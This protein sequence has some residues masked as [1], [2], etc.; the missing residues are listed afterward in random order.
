MDRPI[1]YPGQTPAVEDLLGGFRGSYIG[2]GTLLNAVMDAGTVVADGCAITKTGG[3]GVSIAPGS[4]HQNL[5][6]APDPNGYGVLGAANS[7]AGVQYLAPRATALTLSAGVT[8]YIYA[9]G[10]SEQDGNDIVLPYYNAS[11]PAVPFSGAN[12]S[13]AAQPT[14]RSDIMTIAAQIGSV[15][16]GG[17]QLYTVQVPGGAT[18]LSGATITPSGAFLSYKLPGLQPHLAVLGDTFIFKFG[19]LVVQAFDGPP[20]SP[21]AA[22]TQS[23][24]AF[25]FPTPFPTKCAWAGAID[26]GGGLLTWNTVIGLSNTGGTIGVYCPVASPGTGGARI[27]AVG[28]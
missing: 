19:P 26:G 8:W 13:G 4:L 22:F 7:P 27:L 16:S 17:V 25:T 14:T 3:F 10:A 28:Y 18:D 1:I 15:P 21:G 12:N 6:I 5:A 20:V 2:L 9:T 23:T 11:S 24:A